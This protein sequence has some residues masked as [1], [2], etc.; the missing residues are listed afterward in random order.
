[1]KDNLPIGEDM[2]SNHEELNS[3]SC[4]IE[5]QNSLLATFEDC[6]DEA[7]VQLLKVNGNEA[8]VCSIVSNA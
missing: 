1:M 2:P 7:N 4:Q 8:F 3:L 6:L 5:A